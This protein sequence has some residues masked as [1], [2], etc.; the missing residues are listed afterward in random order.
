MRCSQNKEMVVHRCMPG[1]YIIAALVAVLVIALGTGLVLQL[2][3]K[4][5]LP[6]QEPSIEQ[7][8]VSTYATSTFSISYPPAFTVDD[9]YAYEGVP[10]KKVAGVKFS[11]PGAMA[12]DTNLSSDSY[13]SVESLPRAKKCTGDIYL[14]QNVRSVEMTVGSSTYSV[15]TTTGVAAGN[16]YEE[17][18]YALTGSN[19]CTAVRY[20]IHSGA[21]GNYP[22]G[23]VREFDRSA[24]LSAFDAIRNSLNLNQ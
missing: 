7:P 11:I 15:A 19:P 16:L 2:R 20:Y 4:S 18:V 5:V 8:Q 24:L 1:K 21:I 13:I 17:Q 14:Y 22:E 23:T 12:T 3:G 6:K 10:K 9:G